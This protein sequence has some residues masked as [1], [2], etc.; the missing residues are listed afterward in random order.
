MSAIK[1][2]SRPKNNCCI[3]DID[4]TFFSY[5]KFDNNLISKLN[6][7]S[8]LKIIVTARSN[9][10]AA[11]DIADRSGL[12]YYSIYCNEKSIDPVNFKIKC[13]EDISKTFSIDFALDDNLKIIDAY[14]MAGV[15]S[16]TPKEFNMLRKD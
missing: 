8:C 9:R 15:P 2:Y 16:L 4:G 1:N 14:V 6:S 11:E 13:C 5:G 12:D 10:S 7:I 3:V